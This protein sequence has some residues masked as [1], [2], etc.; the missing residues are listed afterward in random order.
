MKYSQST[1]S[2]FPK[3]ELLGS[4]T[5]LE[6]KL[7]VYIYQNSKYSFMLTIKKNETNFV[8][9]QA[10]ISF[11]ER[12]LES[13]NLLKRINISGLK[14]MNISIITNKP[15]YGAYFTFDP[16]NNVLLLNSTSINNQEY[17]TIYLSFKDSNN[18]EYN[19]NKF[20]LRITQDH[21]P[22]AVFS[23]DPYIFYYGNLINLIS[24][25]EN[26]FI[27]ESKLEYTTA[28]WYANKSGI[29]SYSILNN[30]DD[31]KISIKLF[32]VKDFIG[33]WNYSIIASDVLNQTSLIT[34]HIQVVPW[35]QTDWIRWSGPYQIDWELWANGYAL[36]KETGTWYFIDY[37]ISYSNPSFIFIICIFIVNILL[38]VASFFLGVESEIWSLVIYI[39][40]SLLI[41]CLFESTVSNNFLNFMSI[42]QLSKLDFKLLD[43][44]FYAR[45]FVNSNFYDIQ[46]VNM[47][48]LSFASGST[49]A[50][51]INLL[52]VLITLLLIFAVFKIIKKPDVDSEITS[53]I[54]HVIKLVNFSLF[55]SIF[56]LSS[57]FIV[58]NWLS[59]LFNQFVLD[60]RKGDMLSY[61]ISD[62]ILILILF[63]ILF[64]H[65]FKPK[66]SVFSSQLIIEN[67]RINLIKM[68]LFAL[69]FILKDSWIY[70]R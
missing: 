66:Y 25:A 36:D 67:D 4:E 70:W 49:F 13:F 28:E 41:L 30:T 40:Q 22:V 57:W 20:N 23:H 14:E 53:W 52:F 17:S 1:I 45:N 11:V 29:V 37:T 43:V 5:T 7:D 54:N 31:E 64:Q 27:D 59:E 21:P 2:L 34:L 62:F 24:F 6:L 3:W 46:Y 48:I 42:L 44:I 51:F 8:W 63:L 16:N 33:K 19:T 26:P 58:M 35:A 47:K 69:W 12:V 10:D 65:K 39:N 9:D 68:S 60:S 61:T 38:S 50:N 15:F 56:K 18:T 32:F 55:V